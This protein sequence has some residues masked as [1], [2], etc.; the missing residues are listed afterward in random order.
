MFFWGG[1]DAVNDLRW[2]DSVIVREDSDCVF[3]D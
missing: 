3:S 2:D 1:I